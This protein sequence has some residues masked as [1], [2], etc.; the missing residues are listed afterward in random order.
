MLEDTRTARCS[1]DVYPTMETVNA[2]LLRVAASTMNVSDDEA[3]MK[4][5]QKLM[6]PVRK[7]AKGMALV[8]SYQYIKRVMGHLN[9]SL[10]SVAVA[11]FVKHMHT[12]KGMGS[13]SSRSSSSARRVL[14]LSAEECSELLR[15]DSFVIDSCGRLAMLEALTSVI[16][17]VG[18]TPLMVACSGPNKTSRV[19]RCLFGHFA[20]VSFRVSWS[21]SLAVLGV[22]WS[23]G[24]VCALIRVR[25][26]ARVPKVRSLLLTLFHFASLL[27]CLNAFSPPSSLLQGA[28]LPSQPC[29][30]ATVEHWLRY[31]EPGTSVSV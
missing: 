17:E 24:V 5:Q 23:L 7:P 16:E 10:T 13:W 22:V 1:D 27:V 26:H 3:A 11:A 15:N 31:F 21:Y 18:G 19:I 14:K 6:L 28:S 8:V 30:P 25:G 29:G 9:S 4:L 2:S 20:N 12:L